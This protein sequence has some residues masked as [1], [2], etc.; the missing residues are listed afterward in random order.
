[1]KKVSRVMTQSY[2]TKKKEHESDVI[3]IITII[4]CVGSGS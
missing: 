2:V 1:M 4:F 3:K